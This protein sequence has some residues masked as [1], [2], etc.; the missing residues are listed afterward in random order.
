VGQAY[1]GKASLGTGLADWQQQSA[2]YGTQEGFSI[3]SS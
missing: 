3:T 1:T 2:S